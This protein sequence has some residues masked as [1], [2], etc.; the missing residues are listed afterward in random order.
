MIFCPGTAPFTANADADA[1]RV[2][3]P[4]R[5]MV[6][7]LRRDTEH[8]NTENFY[9]HPRTPLTGTGNRIRIASGVAN[10]GDWYP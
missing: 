7:K 6:G 2:S 3:F 9:P 8:G 5:G 4:H 10:K 1:G